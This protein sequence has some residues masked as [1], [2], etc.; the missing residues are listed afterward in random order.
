MK[1]NVITFFT[2][3][4]ILFSACNLTDDEG[5]YT[6]IE[7]TE[8]TAQLVEADNEF[9]FELFHKVYN[10]ETEYENIMVSPLSISLALAMTY[11]GANGE[12]QKAMEETLK[13]YGLAP[14]EINTSYH[15]LIEALKSLDKKVILEIANAIFYRD[16]FQ[17][18]NDFVSINKNY[19][20]AEV[21]AL[22]FGNE[23]QSLKTINGWVAEKTHNKIESI[24][25]RITRDHVMFLLNA[26]YFKGIWQSEFE[27]K[28]TKKRDFF[29]ENGS[30]VKTDFMTQENTVLYTANDLFQAVQLPYG[31]GN[32][33]MT[34]FLPQEGKSLQEFTE[35]LGKESWENWNDNFAERNVDIEFPK[36][37]FAYEITLNDVLTE[38][39]MGIAFTG[40][41]DFTGINRGGG[42]NID[43]VKHKSFIEVNE[44]GTEAAAV[45]VVAIERTSAGG[46]TKVPFIANR[47]FL[48]TITEKSTGAILFMGT[49]K[50]PQKD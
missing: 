36:F 27:K 22:D 44:E 48:F 43:Y 12:T 26:I 21:S 15:T 17:V 32:F 33:S 28:N 23:Q 30:A 3:A 5:I 1:R 13:L 42:L 18:E 50:N 41:A 37:K 2:T 16:D 34:V 47:P 10:A 49:V 46:S 7:L 38:M 9:G 40:A 20:D 24:I 19:Y 39:G 11:N 6:E 35:N 4:A 29:L 14:G 8:K 25:D 45:T 31:Q